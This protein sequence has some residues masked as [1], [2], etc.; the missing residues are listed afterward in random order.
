MAG[1]ES[2]QVH[3]QQVG[4]YFAGQDFQVE[5]PAFFVERQVA[6][7][8]L[9]EK[10][11]WSIHHGRDIAL[12]PEAEEYL[13]R[14][15]DGR[16]LVSDLL[17]EESCVMG[18]RVMDANVR[19]EIWAQR[20]VRSWN[21]QVALAEHQRSLKRR[22]LELSAQDT[23]G[24]DPRSAIRRDVRPTARRGLRS[25]I[26]RGVPHPARAAEATVRAASGQ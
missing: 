22:H 26:R 10:K 24:Q 9:N 14:Q 15:I 16:K 1:K 19:E 23:A 21:R 5:V 12:Q 20:M 18:E 2:V 7:Q 17:P 8:W 6:R 11:A 13:E 25:T 3:S 4:V